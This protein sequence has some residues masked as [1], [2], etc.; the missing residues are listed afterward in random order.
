[1]GT[2]A[3]D[4]SVT[5]AENGGVITA[6]LSGLLLGTV[7]FQLA[8]STT[9]F[10]LPGQSFPSDNPQYDIEDAGPASLAAAAL[11]LVDGNV[12]VS[13][14][15]D[16]ATNGAWFSCVVPYAP[17]DSN[18]GDPSASLP[19]G[20]YGNCITTNGASGP[21]GSLGTV[22]L[23]RSGATVTAAFS[24]D[25]VGVVDTTVGSDGG[26]V[27]TA[28]FTV[29]APGSA[30]LPP[31]PSIAANAACGDVGPAAA[32]MIDGNVLFLSGGDDWDVFG[33]ICTAT[34]GTQPV[35]GGSAEGG[36][37]DASV[38]AATQTG[39]TV[40][41]CS[42]CTSN[43]FCVAST[44]QGDPC[45]RPDGGANDC[46]SGTH[47]DSNANCC[48]INPQTTYTCWPNLPSCGGTLSCDCASGVVALACGAV[49]GNCTLFDGGLA[50]EQGP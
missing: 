38:L 24:S 7:S 46:P 8:T 47:W 19:S 29:T 9:A 30:S 34:G 35:V 41:A 45:L 2:S 14:T 21:G 18:P 27:S 6:Q 33:V 20:T 31:G 25:L 48:E 3:G 11:A 13:L 4:G 39:R 43:E 37:A 36:A 10:A 23:T 32:L 42:S 49:P 1:M 12:V 26:F 17:C 28:D 5:L 22:T 15:G 50:C 40:A 16:G 44:F